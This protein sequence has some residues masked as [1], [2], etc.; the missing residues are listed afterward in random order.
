MRLA[1]LRGVLALLVASPLL[2]ACTPIGPLVATGPGTP[3]LSL[4]PGSWTAERVEQ[5][6]AIEAAP[7]DAPVF[8]SPCHPVV[9]TYIDALVSVP[10]GYL[11]LGHDQPPSHA[12]LW[13]SVEA[14]SWKRATDLPAPE[15][16]SIAAAVARPDGTVVAVGESGGVGAVW[17][18]LHGADWTLTP[19]PAPA[20]KATERLTA[21]VATSDAYMAGGYVESATA[22]RSASL[23]RSL[24]GATWTR[25][26]IDLPTGSSQVTGIAAVDSERLVAVGIAGDERRGT[27]AVWLSSDGGATWSSVTSPAFALGRMLAITAGGPG[28]VAVG[29]LQMQTGAVAWYSTEGSTWGSP[30]RAGLDNGGRQMV[31]TAVARTGSGVVAAGWQADAGNGS[32]V[33]WQSSDGL[34]WV[35]TP[36]EAT[37]SGAGLSS[38]LGSPKLMVAGTMGWP[39]THAAEVWTATGG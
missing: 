13:T 39:D 5:P 9:G 37:F 21:V 36:Q 20:A 6:E 2:A 15:A 31:M 38:V 14:E 33:V 26:S 7:T 11:G 3:Y 30:G 35:H 24:D 19:L 23:W 32:A 17:K 29:E 16:S 18:G 25:S 8:C 4:G 1:K 27:S 22:V 34:T 10:G 12:A 28:L